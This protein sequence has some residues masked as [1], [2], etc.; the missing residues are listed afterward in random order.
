MKIFRPGFPVKYEGEPAPAEG[1]Q[2]PEEN[3]LPS[4]AEAMKLAHARQTQILNYGRTQAP[5]IDNN[6]A[7]IPPGQP[8][9]VNDKPEVQE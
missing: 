5:L 8:H 9:S 1:E 4:V 7:V 6:S 2:A 3:P